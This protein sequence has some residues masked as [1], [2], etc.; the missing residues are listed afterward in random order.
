MAGIG[1]SDL[2]Q[3]GYFAVQDESAGLPVLLLDPKPGERVLDLCSAPGGKTAFIGECMK[4]EGRIVAVDRYDSR[5]NL[6]RTACQRLGVTIVEFLSADATEFDIPAGDKVLVDAPC[7]GLG[8]LAKKPDAK[9]TRE[10]EDIEDLTRL[11]RGIIGHAAGLVKPG[12]VLVYSTCTI[13]PE[14]NALLIG[15]FLNSHPEFALESAAPFVHADLVTA[16]GYVQTFQHVHGMDGSFC[17][18]LRKKST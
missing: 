5:L 7:S 17:V 1:G 16:E 9:W 2:L 8:I 10:P 13:E 14:E 18:R 11:Q 6:V 4:N 12:G 3:Q 15:E